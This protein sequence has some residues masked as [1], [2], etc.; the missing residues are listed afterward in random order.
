M[1][2]MHHCLLKGDYQRAGRAWRMILSA[3]ESNTAIDPRPHARW[4]IEAEMR[5]HC[6]SENN[7]DRT[8]NAPLL[9]AD[10][11]IFTEEGFK[12]AREYYESLIIKYPFHQS[13]PRVTNDLTFYPAMFGMW[14]YEVSQVSRTAIAAAENSDSPEEEREA[15]ILTARTDELRRAREIAARLDD[16]LSHPHY[17]KRADFLHLRGMLH[18]WIGDLIAEISQ[19]ERNIDA[20]VSSE[21]VP[22]NRVNAE[23]EEHVAKAK[24]MFKRAVAN[25]GRLSGDALQ[26]LGD[27]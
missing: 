11:A 9:D 20:E 15:Q 19:L 8:I 7:V 27:V 21:E 5:L 13:Q 26:L 6:G 18:L 23:R 10:D 24:E 17:D 12:A 1:T 3:G 16:R 14:I 2:I 4:G 25:G 22:E